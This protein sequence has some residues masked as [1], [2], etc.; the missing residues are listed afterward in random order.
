MLLTRSLIV[1]I[2]D[3]ANCQAKAQLSVY[4]S[5]LSRIH[6][7]VLLL[8]L[9]LLLY[10][11]RSAVANPNPFLRLNSNLRSHKITSA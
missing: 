4:C 10:W 2:T 3:N 5:N 8:L 1:E 11:G 6:S 9:Q 7:V